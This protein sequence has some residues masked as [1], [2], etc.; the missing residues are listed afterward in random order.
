MENSSDDNADK[1]DA[2]WMYCHLANTVVT[3]MAAYM[4]K[5]SYYLLLGS[6]PLLQFPLLSLISALGV[7]QA[8]SQQQRR[9]MHA[10]GHYAM[11]NR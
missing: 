7:L 5:S 9:C 1:L 8:C 4:L 2:L 10:L 11:H 3:A 6:E